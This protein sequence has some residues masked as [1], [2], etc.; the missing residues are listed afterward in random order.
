MGRSNEYFW[1]WLLLLSMGAVLVRTALVFF[2]PLDGDGLVYLATALSIAGGHGFARPGQGPETDLMPLYPLLAAP[3]MGAGDP[4]LLGRWPSLAAGVLL[5][6]LVALLGTRLYG[7]GPGLLAAGLIALHPPLARASANV[8][9]HVLYG[10]L[11]LGVILLADAPLRRAAGWRATTGGLLGL[12]YLARP[13][14]IFYLPVVP[15]VLGSASRRGERL[16][17]ALGC[18]AAFFAIAAPYWIHLY[19]AT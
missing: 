5:V 3:L 8:Q 17:V 1:R 18:L 13:E 11:L 14:A 9:P 10:A 15:L 4:A 7:P 2:V 19:S 12:A 6:P 16:A